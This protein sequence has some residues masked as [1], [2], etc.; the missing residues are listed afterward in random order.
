MKKLK[1][2]KIIGI[3][4]VARSGKDTFCLLSAKRLNKSKQAAMRCA[5]ADN[6]KADLHQLLIKKAGLSAYT[7]IDKEK[8]LI[9]PLLVAYGTNLMRKMDPEYW[10]KRLDLTIKAAMQVEA[11][12]FITDVRYINEVEWVKKQGGVMVHIEK[13][14]ALPANEQEEINDPL[15]K[16][17]CD[18]LVKWDHVGEELLEKKLS[19][20]VTRAL[21]KLQ[22]DDNS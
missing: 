5:F 7:D 18:L 21:G 4:G 14:G 13:E 2:P 11:T 1:L 19:S 12:A 6:V 3:S 16:A 8:E 9:R 22:V 20:K 17:E 15:I 10:I